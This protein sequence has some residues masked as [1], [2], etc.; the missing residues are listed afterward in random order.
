MMTDSGFPPADKTEWH[1]SKI[2][3]FTGHRIIDKKDYD[4]LISRLNETIAALIGQGITRFCSGG[5][6]GFD[7][8]AAAAVL[9]ARER[10]QDVKLIMVLPCFD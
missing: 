10:D 4:T 5:A 7:Y 3:A 2:A 8:M 1:K 6:V 9:E